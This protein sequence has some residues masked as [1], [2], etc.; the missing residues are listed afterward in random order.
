MNFIA[1]R[2]KSLIMRRPPTRNKL[3]F[4]RS[5][6]Y[7]SQGHTLRIDTSNIC[8]PLY[9]EIITKWQEYA[10]I[11]QNTG[12]LYSF[13]AISTEENTKLLRVIVND[14]VYD[15]LAP[16][17]RHKLPTIIIPELFNIYVVGKELDVGLK[18]KVMLFF[19]GMYPRVYTI[20]KCADDGRS[21]NFHLRRFRCNR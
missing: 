15:T 10:E 4:S 17:Q 11:E 13:E 18:N 6:H 2:S 5:T 7:G 16:L 14:V 8:G 9:L 20:R 3:V 12:G 21:I 19:Y 1:R